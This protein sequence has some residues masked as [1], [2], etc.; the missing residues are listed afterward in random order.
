MEKYIIKEVTKNLKCHEKI[1]VKI[2]KKTFIKVCNIVRINT[3]NVF[4]NNDS[5]N[6]K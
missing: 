1:T 2:F 6:E 5:G 4:I 3:I